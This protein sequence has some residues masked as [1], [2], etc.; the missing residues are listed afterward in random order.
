[1]TLPRWLLLIAL[2][3]G[4]GL[5]CALWWNAADRAER[6]AARAERDACVG[7]L[8]KHQELSVWEAFCAE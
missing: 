2:A 5:L 3:F 8:V 1:M 4:C 7:E 6:D